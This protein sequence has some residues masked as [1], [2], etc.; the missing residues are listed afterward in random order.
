MA[1]RLTPPTLSALGSLML[2][3]AAAYAQDPPSPPD[4]QPWRID[5]ATDVPPALAAAL[6]A[7]ECRQSDAML[8]TFPIE[9][10]RPAGSRVMAIAPCSG[11]TL[12]GRAFM[13][14]RGTP[15]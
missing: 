4:G 7:A 10:F 11:I 3:I 1:H 5:R 6:S 8:V 12:Y 13:F 9:L 15:L 14:E 2:C